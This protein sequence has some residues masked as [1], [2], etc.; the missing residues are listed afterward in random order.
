MANK[1][2]SVENALLDLSSKRFRSIRQSAAFHGVSKATLARRVRGQRA[3][4][5]LDANS[6]RLSST[7]EEVLMKWI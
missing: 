1:E 4:V 2:E 5:L 7:K 3:R 6:S